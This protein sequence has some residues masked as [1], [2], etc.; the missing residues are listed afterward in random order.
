MDK[1]DKYIKQLEMLIAENL[2]PT[3]NKYYDLIKEPKP[4]LDIPIS[5]KSKELPALLRGFPMLT[6]DVRKP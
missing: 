3:Y 2:L 1:R 5:L 6:P 4:E